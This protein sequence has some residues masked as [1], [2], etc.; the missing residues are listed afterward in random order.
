M[1]ATAMPRRYLG[2]GS[3]W[4]RD[5]A[6]AAYRAKC[7]TSLIICD[8]HLS[9]QKFVALFKIPGQQRALENTS[10]QIPGVTAYTGCR[11]NGN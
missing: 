11:E 3:S 10:I 7:A 8:P 6:L 9:G 1:F 4:R 2:A 5:A